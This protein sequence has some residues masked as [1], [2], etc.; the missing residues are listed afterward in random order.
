MLFHLFTSSLISFNVVLYSL[1][2]KYFTSFVIL[3]LNYFKPVFLSIF[4]RFSAF[5]LVSGAKGE[6]W[7]LFSVLI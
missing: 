7:A 4:L 6:T 1:V 3:I 5:L 2:Y